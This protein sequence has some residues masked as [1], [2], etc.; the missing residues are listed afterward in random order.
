MHEMTSGRSKRALTER[1][2]RAAD[3]AQLGAW[4]RSL[5]INEHLD[6]DGLQNAL[7]L[8]FLAPWPFFGLGLFLPGSWWPRALC[9]VVGLVFLCTGIVLLRKALRTRRSGEGLIHLFEEGAVL[10]R[11]KGR[12]FALPYT[13]TPVEYVSWSERIAD[14]GDERPRLHFWITTPDGGAVMLD[15]WEDWEFP[16]LALIAQRWGLAEPHV[17]PQEPEAPPVW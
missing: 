16:D 13:G 17:V 6:K 8:V 9:V 1:G 15:A 10:E 2:R 12:I 4:E 7:M 14:S 5:R 3:G 11:T